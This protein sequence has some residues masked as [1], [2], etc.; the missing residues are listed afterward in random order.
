MVG[1]EK[2]SLSA[3]RRAKRAEQPITSA[4]LPFLV[5]GCGGNE[6]RAEGES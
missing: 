2:V 6:T 4:T 1:C 3:R 5:L